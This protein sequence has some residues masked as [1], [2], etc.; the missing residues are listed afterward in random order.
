[1]SFDI[2]NQIDFISQ[3]SSLIF[4]LLLKSSHLNKLSK[5]SQMAELVKRVLH[6]LKVVGS[7]P[8]LVHS[9]WL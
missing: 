4:G 6:D 8:A 9:D 2:Q 7:I 5:Q 1:M 3:E